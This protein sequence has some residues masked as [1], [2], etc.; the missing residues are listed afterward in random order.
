VRSSQSRWSAW[1]R[2]GTRAAGVCSA[3]RTATSTSKYCTTS[4]EPRATSH[5]L[6]DDVDFDLHDV[7]L[8]LHVDLDDDPLHDEHDDAEAR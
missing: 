8:D 2:S 3:T 7:D 1:R 5:E 6:D 4:H